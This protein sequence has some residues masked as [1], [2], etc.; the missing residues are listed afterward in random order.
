MKKLIVLILC[1]LSLVR[2]QDQQNF[3]NRYRLGQSYEVAG[4]YEKAES[5]YR[6]LINLQPWN[7]AYFESLNKV[8]VLNKKYDEAIQIALIKIRTNPQDPNIY[9][10]LGTTYFIMDDRE[11]AYSTW[12]KGIT[13]NSDSYITYRVIANYAIENRAYE[14]AIDILKRGKKI[15]QDITFF[16]IDLANLYAVNMDFENAALEFCELI[17]Y[18]PGQLGMAKSRVSSYI[19][20]PL[21]AQQTV[22][23]I[24]KAI[25]AQP[26]SILYDFLVFVYQQTGNYS[27][28]FRTIEKS[29]SEYNGN[30]TMAFSFAQDAYRDQKFDWSAKTYDYILKKYPNSPYQISARIGYAKSLEEDLNLKTDS[31]LEL[32]KPFLIPTI[33]NVILYEKI[34]QAYYD[35]KDEFKDNSIIAEALFRIAEIYRKRLLQLDKA[36]S[37]YKSVIEFSPRGSYISQSNIARGKIAILKNNFDLAKKYFEDVITQPQNDPQSVIE[38]TYYRSRIEFWR[39]NFTAAMQ[40]LKIVTQDLSYDYVNDA[41]E[42]SFLIS[43]TKKD[44]TNL[45]KYAFAELLLLQNNL[46]GAAT[47]LKTLGDNDNLF[48]INQ[49]AKNKL[50]EIFL[51]E[52][53]YSSAAEILKTIISDEKNAIFVDKSTYYLGL[54]YLYGLKDIGKA[55]ESLEKILEIFPNSIYFDLAR[56]KLNSI[57]T[58]Y[59]QK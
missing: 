2:A 1:T 13:T 9:G 23:G 8:L 15:N 26:S 35:F 37:I 16:S 7:Y 58:N 36:D 20:R 53:D 44:S 49:F 46:K 40:Q 47:E 29:E 33:R 52:N 18:Q 50:A 17:N 51:A 39:G 5:I 19:S 41:L 11:N 21:A 42:I 38:A 48:I 59:G 6:E 45:L 14:K 54:T 22:S 55:T 12:E 56:E 10:I 27:E 24:K 32:W 3:D 43:S 4:Q 30:G 25:T 57:K 31:T 34:I 28:A